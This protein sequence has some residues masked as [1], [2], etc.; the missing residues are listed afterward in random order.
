MRFIHTNPIVMWVVE[1]Q[2]RQKDDPEL[3]YDPQME[4]LYSLHQGYQ[5]EFQRARKIGYGR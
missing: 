1:K 2:F 4:D 5:Y 3:H